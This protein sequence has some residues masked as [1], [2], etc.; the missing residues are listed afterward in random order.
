M[1][2]YQYS[3][4]NLYDELAFCVYCIVQSEMSAAQSDITFIDRKVCIKQQNANNVTTISSQLANLN[5]Y[6][7]KL[8]VEPIVE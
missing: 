8:L 4:C 2:K 6:T 1:E 5:S 3:P 7:I